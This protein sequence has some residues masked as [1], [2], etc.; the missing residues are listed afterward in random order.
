MAQLVFELIE[1]EE[2]LASCHERGG[3]SGGRNAVPAVEVQALITEV[4]ALRQ[5]S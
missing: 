3:E 5:E 2:L 4:D 1:K